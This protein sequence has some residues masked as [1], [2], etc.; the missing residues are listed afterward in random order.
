M[1]RPRGRARAGL[2]LSSCSRH[3]HLHISHNFQASLR[4]HR[5]PGPR[6]R[7]R[8]VRRHRWSTF[9]RAGFLASSKLWVYLGT[10]NSLGPTG[11]SPVLEPLVVEF[12]RRLGSTLSCV[13]EGRPVRRSGCARCGYPGRARVPVS[14][15]CRSCT[16]AGSDEPPLSPFFLSLWPNSLATDNV[17]TASRGGPGIFFLSCFLSLLSGPHRTSSKRAPAA[18]RQICN[19]P[20][21]VLKGVS[22]FSC[23][24]LWDVIEGNKQPNVAT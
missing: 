19:F 22:C 5:R 9:P 24:P 7:R 2:G 16:P 15:V 12:G 8:F 18:D 14:Q 23:A 3:G 4:C 17:H 20:R 13:W 21:R 11:V 10:S 6:P 1:Y